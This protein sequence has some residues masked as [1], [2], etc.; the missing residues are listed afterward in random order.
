MEIKP[1]VLVLADI[2]GYTRFIRFHRV[3]LI[4]AERIVTELLESVI[5]STTVPLVVHELEGDAVAFYAVDD[6]PTSYAGDVFTHVERFIEAFRVREAE[7]ISECSM[8][9]CEACQNVGKLRLKAVLHRGE[10]VFGTLRQFTKVAGEDVILAHRLL[11]N[12]VPSEEY[13]LMTDQFLEACPPAQRASP[14]RRIEQVEGLGP[15]AVHVLDLQREAPTA[16]PRSFKQR[17]RTFGA[18]E[19][20]WIGRFFRP[21]PRNYRNLPQ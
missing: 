5:A 8:C 9:A 18:V 11:K 4:H 10:A 3:S 21:A 13:I 6:G 2:S 15:I 12:S 16:T 1:V 20:Y 14:A 7:L 19:A 17:L